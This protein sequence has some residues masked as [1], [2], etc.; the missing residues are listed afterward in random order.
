M[1][2]D[3][4]LEISA[5]LK[6]LVTAFTDAAAALHVQMSK[7]ARTEPYVYVM[8]KM[9]LELKLSLSYSENTLK[10]FFKKSGTEKTSEV[11]S[12]ISLEVVAVPRAPAS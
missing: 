10:G 8:P 12:M 4:E 11:M 2:V 1:A 5:L 7:P 6:T 3:S 9:E